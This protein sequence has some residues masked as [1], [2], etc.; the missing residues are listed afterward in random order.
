MDHAPSPPLAH[1]VG[2]KSEPLR[3]V[4]LVAVAAAK[5]SYETTA[6]GAEEVS[7]HC[8]SHLV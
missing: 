6:V 3:L 4:G 1:A 7:G 2:Q 5:R 8:H